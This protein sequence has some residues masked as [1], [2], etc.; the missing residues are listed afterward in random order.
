MQ[1]EGAI[2]R[3][4]AIEMHGDTMLAEAVGGDVFEY[5]NF[6]QRY[7]DRCP[8]RSCEEVCNGVSEAAGEGRKATERS[9]RACSLDRIATT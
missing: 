8:H 4:A 3:L 1:V 6:Q 5:I 7:N 9:R 2:P